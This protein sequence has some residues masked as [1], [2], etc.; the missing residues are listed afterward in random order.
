MHWHLSAKK[1]R[2]HFADVRKVDVF[3][4]LELLSSQLPLH[5]LRALLLFWGRSFNFVQPSSCYSST[6]VVVEMEVITATQAW[7]V[8]KVCD[9]RN[10][11]KT[12]GTEKDETYQNFGGKDMN[13]DESTQVRRGA[14]PARLLIRQKRKEE[15]L[16]TLRVYSRY[17]WYIGLIRI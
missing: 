14:S 15:V 8:Q 7:R 2:V 6:S 16:H 9:G 13:E 11:R 4:R 12:S 3:H 17:G 5:L 10:P 1:A